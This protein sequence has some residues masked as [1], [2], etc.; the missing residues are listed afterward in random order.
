MLIPMAEC[1]RLA[2]A[3]LSW[4][5][6]ILGMT[7]PSAAVRATRRNTAVGVGAVAAAAALF[8]TSGV[9]TH[10][11]AP[12]LA[13]ATA[14]GWRV[15]IGGSALVVICVAFGAAPWSFPLRWRVIVPGALAFLGFQV[16]YFQ[17][18]HRVGVATAT[19]V[20]IGTG[21]VVAGLLDR[22]RRGAKLKARWWVGVAV[23]VSG[24][25]VMTG[26]GGVQLEPIGWA[27]AIGAGCCFPLFGDAI[28]DLTADRTALAA[29]ATV[30]GAAILPAAVLLVLA[31][32]DPFATTGSVLT[33]LYLG[34]LTTAA[35]YA[36]WSSG[37][38]VLSLGDTVT[39]TMI[40]PIV[41]TALAVAFL[42]EPAGTATVVGVVATLAGVWIATA[43]TRP[44]SG[45]APQRVRPIRVRRVRTPRVGSPRPGSR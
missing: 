21:P 24:I 45:P 28:R 32:T 27:A 12:G 44:E 42:G 2:I 11:L 16:G 30:F 17:A 39:L 34:L 10:L 6:T 33:L 18:I 20:T 15:V 9:A 31:G 23:A 4:S 29:V 22:V 3:C 43:P 35:A 25:G 40:E 14:A 19:I 7:T 13:A 41:A 36:L 1:G 38:A 26:A 5:D 8:G 37:L